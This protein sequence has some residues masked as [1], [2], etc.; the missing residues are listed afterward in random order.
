MPSPEPQFERSA[1]HP[2]IRR[3]LVCEAQSSHL[4]PRWEE[5]LGPAV[6]FVPSVA[7]LSARLRSGRS[8]AAV[9]VGLR[10]K[11][12]LTE[13]R[14]LT[15]RMLQLAELQSLRVVVD[16]RRCDIDSAVSLVERGFL[17]SA[18]DLDEKRS[19]AE[20]VVGSLS[21][22]DVLGDED[23]CDRLAKALG[24]TSVSDELGLSR[25]QHDVLR[26]LLDYPRQKELAVKLGNSSSTVNTHA[27]AI[28]AR[29]GGAS[30]EE[31]LARAHAG[32]RR[33]AHVLGRL[34]AG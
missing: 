18:D 28:S 9:C 33:A 3:I 16:V 7:A 14:R 25:A 8:A 30:I 15:D 2:S 13:R 27:S 20:L 24:A 4:R 22:S 32:A 21:H 10:S 26:G 29:A 6:E 1:V 17:L 34:L 19:A 12:V 23:R 11:W 5:D 31:V